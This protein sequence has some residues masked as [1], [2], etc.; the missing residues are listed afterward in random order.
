VVAEGRLHGLRR[1]LRHGLVSARTLHSGKSRAA[2]TRLAL[3]QL[4]GRL[5][6]DAVQLIAPLPA[7]V[8]AL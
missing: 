7:Q 6:E 4:E 8:A 2:T 3:G 5:R 1:H